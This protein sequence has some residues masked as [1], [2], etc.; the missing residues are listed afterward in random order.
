MN[1]VNIIS[2]L[3]WLQLVEV[4]V[5]VVQGGQV[6]VAEEHRGTPASNGS[7]AENII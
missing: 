3:R 1:L 5:E 6:A 2:R 4:E 7:H